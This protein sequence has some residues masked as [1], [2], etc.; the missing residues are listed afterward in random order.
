[1]L[2]IIFLPAAR[3]YIKKIKDKKLKKLFKDAVEAIQSDYT[4]GELKKGDLAGIYSYDIFYDRTNYELSYT[5]EE[6]DGK[7]IVVI[8]A[9][10][11]ENF[12]TELKKYI[13]KTGNR[14]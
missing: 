10:T 5:T 9:G 4:I 7:I 2:D 3:N 8:M 6:V 13:S 1:M 14:K 11:R 12:Y